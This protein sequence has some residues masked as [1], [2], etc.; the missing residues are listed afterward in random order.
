MS[1]TKLASVR[2]LVLGGIATAAV[3]V[4]L[5]MIAAP[6]QAATLGGCTVTPL[7]PVVIGQV[8]GQ[9]NV[10][11]R[12]RVTCA[13]DRIVQ[14]RDNR[15]EADAPAGV[16]NDFNYG[17]TTYLETFD[18][19]QTIIVRVNDVVTSTENSNEE[20]YHRTSFRVATINGVSNWTAFQNSPVLSV[21]N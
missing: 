13:P 5:T 8:G 10:Q 14:I 9:P 19:Q 16:G 7:V 20:A 3:A 11:Y 17:T 21:N 6:A 4:P 18:S 2:K 15:R 12:T 1:R